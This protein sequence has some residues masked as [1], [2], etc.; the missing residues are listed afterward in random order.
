ML[1]P[2]T[3]IASLLQTVKD[4]KE[5]VILFAPLVFCFFLYQDNVKMRQDMLKLQQ[6]QAHATLKI[7]EA[8]TQQVELIRRIDYTVTSLQ[9]K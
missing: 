5:I 2:T 7:S 3:K 4:Y 1:M 6:D 8:M 9:N